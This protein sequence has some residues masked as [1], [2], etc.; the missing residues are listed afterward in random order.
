MMKKLSSGNCVYD[1]KKIILISHVEKGTLL[2]SLR[3]FMENYK[4][5]KCQIE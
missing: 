1:W 2:D 3:L 4:S 5:I